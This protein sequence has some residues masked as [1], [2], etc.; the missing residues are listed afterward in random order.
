M[1]LIVERGEGIS[2]ASSF[3]S[4]TDYHGFMDMQFIYRMTKGRHMEEPD[5]DRLERALR[6]AAYLLTTQINW[7]GCRVSKTQY[8]AWPRAQML[9]CDGQFVKC[10]TVPREIVEANIILAHQLLSGEIAA[11]SNEIDAAIESMSTGN[12]NVKF[13]NGGAH[14]REME[15]SDGAM[16]LSAD[17]FA[18]VR[19]LI[20][21][22]VKRPAKSMKLRR[23]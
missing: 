21:C 9:G 16:T 3:A 5:E 1:G 17:R 15:T 23:A 6:T 18:A 4:V 8:L 19:P 7:R 20:S 12:Y 14:I 2:N 22:F 13:A 11:F 10:C